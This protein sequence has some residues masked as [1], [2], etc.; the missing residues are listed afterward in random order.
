[1]SVADIL[2]EPNLARID[3]IP[4]V[5]ANTIQLAFDLAFESGRAFQEIVE[6]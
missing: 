5:V 3:S 2:L 6:Q 4:P 1:M